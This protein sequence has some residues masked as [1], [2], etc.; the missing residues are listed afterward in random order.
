MGKKFC[1]FVI[2]NHIQWS[3]KGWNMSQENFLSTLSDIFL[4]IL[5][6]IYKNILLIYIWNVFS[7]MCNWFWRCYLCLKSVSL[8]FLQ[9]PAEDNFSSFLTMGVQV[10]IKLWKFTSLD[11]YLRWPEPVKRCFSNHAASCNCPRENYCVSRA[12]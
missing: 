8:N 5:L 1:H 4:P 10:D 11:N 12:P 7:F 2:T 6:L 3:R 9:I